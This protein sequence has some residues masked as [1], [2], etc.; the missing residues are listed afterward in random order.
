VASALH[1]LTLPT[2]TDNPFMVRAA[3]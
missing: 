3:S 2:R 1:A